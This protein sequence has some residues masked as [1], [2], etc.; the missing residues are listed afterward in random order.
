[1]PYKL[2]M[3]HTRETRDSA[4]EIKFLIDPRLAPRIREWAR[5]HMQPDPHGTGPFGDEYQTT[6][7]Y[8][9]TERYD[10]L[11]RRA[12]FGRAKYRVRRYGNADRVF[13]ERKLRKPG[14]L[15]KRRTAAPLAFL[16]RLKDFDGR[17]DWPGGWF[18]QRLVLRRLGPV[19]QVSYQRTARTVPVGDGVARLTLDSHLRVAAVSEAEFTSEPAVPFLERRLIL[20]LKYR[21]HL[22]ALFR[23]LVEEFALAPEAAS[24]YRLGMHAVGHV[25]VRDRPV[26]IGRADASYA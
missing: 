13:L 18:H 19:C 14:V 23:Q 5:A 8:F 1:V 3:V 26:P 9:D 24:K 11:Y 6:S 2:M 15:I 10:V 7:L 25:L 17:I 4:A 22:P 16:E 21:H 20:E 12:S